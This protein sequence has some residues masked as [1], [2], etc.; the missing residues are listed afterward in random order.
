MADTPSR[1]KLERA[2]GKIKNRKAGG[3][4][5][6]LSEMERQLVIN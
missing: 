2:I 1:E 6:I 5:G 4:S 3:S